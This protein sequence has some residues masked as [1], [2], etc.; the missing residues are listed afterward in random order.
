MAAVALEWSESPAPNNELRTVLKTW[1]AEN[2][3]THPAT[4]TRQ[5]QTLRSLVEVIETDKLDYEKL[6]KDFLA[7][8][9]FPK[10]GGEHRVT[11]NVL[12]SL[13]NKVLDGL[14]E[15]GI[16][17]P[18]Q[19]MPVMAQSP[20]RVKQPKVA[21]VVAPEPMQAPAVPPAPV[22]HL[23][24]APTPVPPPVHP[25]HPLPPLVEEPPM[26]MSAF[27]L[28]EPP[29]NLEPRRGKPVNPVAALV[30]PENRLRIYRQGEPG[31]SDAHLIDMPSAMVARY[32]SGPG[33]IITILN[34]VIRPK[35]GPRP[36]ERATYRF[37]QVNPQGVEGNAT[38]RDL[39]GES[40]M[41]PAPV[42]PLTPGQPLVMAPEQ[43]AAFQQLQGQL[44]QL[45]QMQRAPGTVDAQFDAALRTLQEQIEQ[46]KAQIS[47]FSARPTGPGDF[48]TAALGAMT[49]MVDKMLAN[50]P[51]PSVSKEPSMMELLAY[52]QQQAD[53]QRQADR[54]FFQLMFK[55][56]EAPKV[57]PGVLAI[58]ER[59]DARLTAVEE[60][61]DDE[62]DVA[63]DGLSGI[64]K[65]METAEYL[66][67]NMG[68]EAGPT[69]R[70]KEP[71]NVLGLLRELASQ[72]P[73]IIAEYRQTLPVLAAA[74]LGLVETVQV[75]VGPDGKP[76]QQLAGQQQQQPST[77]EQQAAAVRARLPADIRAAV[78][79]LLAATTDDQVAD[80]VGALV[81]LMTQHAANNPQALA[82]FNKLEADVAAGDLD[83]TVIR[84]R[85]IFTFFG[86]SA[87]APVSKV[88][89][90]SQTIIRLVKDMND[91]KAT[92]AQAQAQVQAQAAASPEVGTAQ[93]AQPLPAADAAPALHVVTDPAAPTSEVEGDEEEGDGE[94]EGEEGEED[95]ELD[96]EDGGEEEGDDDAEEEE[97]E[98]E[99][100]DAEEVVA[101]PPKKNG[102]IKN[103]LVEAAAIPPP[104]SVTKLDQTDL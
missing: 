1:L 68:I 79:H 14:R 73:A 18:P 40:V 52:S 15:Q 100:E 74:R 57:D 91:R 3:S 33:A 50:K 102:A 80:A 44:D 24:P 62:P 58:L 19:V 90:L 99:E 56:E 104:A 101:A 71:E 35:W 21:A 55:K 38:E 12:V 17:V 66:K 82:T 49:G 72:V 69:M 65:F 61:A 30:P 2:A 59:I 41:P 54:E 6:P 96:E 45:Q 34:D 26:S 8:H 81:N 87:E 11:Q 75:A 83:N 10:H 23:R 42:P 5:R 31:Q 60:S 92:Q 51:E 22:V 86:Y 94:E 76:V 88:V 97:E 47:G 13:A 84:L 46:L 36:G 16:D 7:K 37:V 20:S 89:A 32:G 93:S 25:N 78:E 95:D 28:P 67:K 53:R 64:K 43:F 4:A 29:S 48:G 39:L 9:W 27:T 98:E 85:Q 70:S 103:G 77:P 63:D